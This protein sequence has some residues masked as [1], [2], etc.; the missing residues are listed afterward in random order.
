MQ[1]TTENVLAALYILVAIMLV[2][3]LYH[4]LF[5]VVDTRKILRRIDDVTA[6]IEAVIMKPLAI[7]DH[8]LQK[9][10][11]LFQHKKEKKHHRG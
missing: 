7:A 3:V 6:Q 9:I 2:I 11:D 8:V 5:I 10:V 1:L 4:T